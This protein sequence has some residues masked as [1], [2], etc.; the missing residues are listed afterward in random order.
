MWTV[1]QIIKCFVV[2]WLYNR[3][4]GGSVWSGH[5]SRYNL[6]HGD[7]EIRRWPTTCTITDQAT[8][9]VHVASL[10]PQWGTL[11]LQSKDK[12][13]YA[14]HQQA[15]A[16]GHEL[17]ARHRRLNPL[18]DI[19]LVSPLNGFS[20]FLLLPQTLCSKETTSC[21]STVKVVRFLPLITTS[22][23]FQCTIGRVLCWH[24]AH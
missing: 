21:A 22:D 20:S 9:T 5:K 23:T 7:G 2:L 18:R 24:I 16:Q 17:C 10:A 15:V 8:A 6:L 13:Q 1:L 11:C 14:T 4:P 19:R 12:V 3:L